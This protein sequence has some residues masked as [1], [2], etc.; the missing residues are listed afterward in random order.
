MRELKNVILYFQMF[1]IIETSIQSQQHAR[2]MYINKTV[3][4]YDCF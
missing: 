4:E 1:S 2:E 3:R